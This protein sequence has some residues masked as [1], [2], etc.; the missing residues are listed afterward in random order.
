MPYKKGK[1]ELDGLRLARIKKEMAKPRMA[2]SARM[3]QRHNARLTHKISW[4]DDEV[5]IPDKTK[6][7]LDGASRLF[8]GCQA[9]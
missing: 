1:K 3:A 8:C 7:R 2:K 9:Y 4:T 5:R 6:S